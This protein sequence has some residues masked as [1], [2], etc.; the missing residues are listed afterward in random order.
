MANSRNIR[1]GFSFGFLLLVIC[2]FTSTP[3]LEKPTWIIAICFFMFY[4]IIKYSNNPNYFRNSYLINYIFL[5]ISLI[6][7]YRL[8]TIS[9][10]PWGNFMNETFFFS[11]IILSLNIEGWK[12]NKYARI[13]WWLMIIIL[14]V[15][16]ADNIRLSILYPQINTNRIYL[17]ESFLARINAGG[18]RFYTFSFLVSLVT[19]FIFLNC[20]NKRIKY[21]MLGVTILAG[22]YILGYCYKASVMVFFTLSI[23]LLYYAK[24]AVKTHRFIAI[25][26]LS[27]ILGFF[28]IT[29]YQDMIIN[30]I[31]AHSPN[32]RITTRLIT[33]ID[34]TNVEANETTISGR[35]NL[36]FLS[37]HTWLSDLQTFL[38]GIG[39]HRATFN[40]VKTR[41]GQHSELFDS[42][43]RYGLLGAFLL[44]NIFKKA[45]SFTLSLFPK[46]CRLQLITIFV[47]VLFC[48]FTK[49]FFYPSAGFAIFILLPLSSIFLSDK[50]HFID[51]GS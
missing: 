8:L 50:E 31:I 29:V 13:I 43:A 49:A 37:V 11:L 22:F 3:I 21:I 2:L 42:L 10:A 23:F 51:Y 15:N 34:S 19:Y 44:F 27:T 9:D 24:I 38:F 41:I 48:G 47:I 28:T 36:Y 6:Y 33:M 26:V 45:L 12:S 39:D 18:S 4:C 40:V 20:E 30:F 46:K 25:L 14:A 1:I 32:Q 17:D 35:T 7:F 16:I 5:Y